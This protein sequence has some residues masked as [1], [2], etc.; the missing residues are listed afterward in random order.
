MINTG[1]KENCIKHNSWCTCEADTD[2]F[3]SITYYLDDSGKWESFEAFGC[4]TFPGQ[5]PQDVEIQKLGNIPVSY[6][7]FNCC[8]EVDFCN[9][10]RTAVINFTFPTSPS[11]ASI[12]TSTPSPGVGVFYCVCLFFRMC[13]NQNSASHK[14]KM[15]WFFTY[16]YTPHT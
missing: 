9:E 11:P 8:D 15:V 13:I 7:A 2:C 12:L 14:K 1:N 10:N 4:F 5:C 6:R 16:V 3:A